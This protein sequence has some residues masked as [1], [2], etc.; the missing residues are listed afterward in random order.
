MRHILL[1]V[2]LLFSAHLARSA[3]I[4]AEVQSSNYDQV[5]GITTVRIVN[6]S[7]KL[8]TAISVSLRLAHPDGTISISQYGGDFLPFMAYAAAS[9]IPQQQGNGGLAPGAVFA[10]EVPTG[11]QLVQTTSATVD[12]VVYDDATADVLNE[13]V[14]RSF[15]LGRKG[16]VLGLQRAA[17][18]LQKALADPNDPHPSITVAGQ[19]KA[20][21]TQHNANPGG[22][23]FEGLGLLDAATDISNAPKSLGRSQKEDDYLRALIKTHEK[24]ISFLLPHTQ[25]TKQVRP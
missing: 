23:A 1:A 19:L 6:T 11:Q 14:F 3:P 10:M 5:K 18:L 15:T 20:L 24:R 22:E 13:P 9:G 17:E 12:V 4:G 16:R 25:L 2:A 8:I 21:A 7:Q